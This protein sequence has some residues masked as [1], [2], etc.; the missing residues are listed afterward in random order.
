MHGPGHRCLLAPPDSMLCAVKH[1]CALPGQQRGADGAV[2]QRVDGAHQARMPSR[3]GYQQHGRREGRGEVA[4]VEQEH[5]VARFYASVVVH[6]PR[7]ASG[8]ED[9]EGCRQPGGLRSRQEQQAAKQGRPCRPLE[10]GGRRAPWCWL[11]GR[12]CT[13]ARWCWLCGCIGDRDRLVCRVGGAAPQGRSP[14]PGCSSR[15][16]RQRLESIQADEVPQHPE[17]D[18][19]KRRSAAGPHTFG[20]STQ[21]DTQRPPG[22]CRASA[23]EVKVPESTQGAPRHPISDMPGAARST[24]SCFAV[25]SAGPRH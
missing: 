22:G 11:G 13:R 4:E 9:E 21:R 5:A 15:G 12:I 3:G 1:P 7:Q 14:R 23:S 6:A 2:G 18:R 10:T 25:S 24:T 19:L 16:S 17:Q 8:A 20:C